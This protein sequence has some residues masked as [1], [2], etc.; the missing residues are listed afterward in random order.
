MEDVLEAHRLVSIGKFRIFFRNRSF[1]SEVPRKIDKNLPNLY[2]LHRD[3]FFLHLPQHR[4]FDCIVVN[5]D[6][7]RRIFEFGFK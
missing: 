1:P 5:K 4:A 6:E 2:I 3:M 7:I